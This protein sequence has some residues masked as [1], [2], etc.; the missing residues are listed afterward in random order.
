[1][2][3][4]DTH[5][6]RTPSPL[7][8][9]STSLGWVASRC[10]QAP[11]H[12]LT[13]TRCL[14]ACPVD[15]LAFH[16]HGDGVSLLASDACHGCGQ[17]VPACPSEALVS[18]EVDALIAKQVE[19]ESLR[20]GCHRVTEGSN[21]HRLHCLRALGPDLLAWLAA[22][23][24][25]E[26]VALDLPH[27]C[28]DCPAALTD[29]QDDWRS[30]AEA[31][32]TIID[33]PA[34]SDF[35][36]ARAA[37]SRRDLLRGRPAPRFPPIAA[38]DAAPKARR[39]QRQKAAAEALGDTRAAPALPGLS[40]TT[41]ACLAHGVCA[42]VCP[43]EALHETQGGELGF[44]P[45]ACL[46]CGHCLTAC[47]E[48]ALASVESMGKE[49]VTLRKSRRIDCFQCGRPFTPNDFEGAST[50][51]ACRREAALMQESFDDLFG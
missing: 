29:T 26:G 5:S 43:T 46:G 47:P 22:R 13:C 16:Q 9:W 7:A 11:P 10:L 37:V 49:A 35:R 17:C 2:P 31:L 14:D 20:L 51:P 8:P 28:R 48:G 39:L 33:T 24:A 45:Q 25:P 12:P 23:A 1:M 30:A 18:A 4:R 34:R 50:C 44:D 38:D 15:A 3:H 27:G 41:D 36:A 6:H 32:A 19:G 40:L 21:Q 42:R